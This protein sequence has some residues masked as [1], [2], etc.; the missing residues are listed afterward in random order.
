MSAPRSG[1]PTPESPGRFRREDVAYLQSLFQPYLDVGPHYRFLPY[2]MAPMAPNYASDRIHTDEHGFRFCHRD[3]RRVTY[4][5]WRTHR[6]GTGLV[7]GG[8]V[9]FGTGATADDRTLNAALNR[10]LPQTLFWN[11]GVG[12]CNGFVE[13]LMYL[14]AGRA[15]DHLVTLSG[16]ND[17]LLHLGSSRRTPPLL[18]F[19]F[20]RENAFA[21]WAGAP[22]GDEERLEGFR[23]IA[24]AL[25][26]DP[27][28]GDVAALCDLPL[29]RDGYDHAVA[30]IDR[31]M[32]IWSRIAPRSF[33][34]VLN[35]ILSQ[36]REPAQEERAYFAIALARMPPVSR[37]QRLVIGVLYPRFRRDV[38]AL[39][40]KHRLPYLDAS[41]VPFRKEPCFIDDFHMT[42]AGYEDL[43]AAI[44][45]RIEKP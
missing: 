5:E 37:C 40:A 8:S 14:F 7:T 36:V 32:E 23:E 39:A 43:A 16:A 1:I 44:A 30:A 31:Q 35:P 24:E 12:A 45:A 2:L 9:V 38:A 20:D 42:D 18:S 13:I 3:G 34:F 11:G 41:T 21:D 19:P 33:L 25:G 26:P 29:V 17:L 15:V 10:R 27:S 28:A 4:E 22:P 6:G